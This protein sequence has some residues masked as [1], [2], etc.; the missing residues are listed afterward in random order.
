MGRTWMPLAWL[1]AAASSSQTCRSA[2]RASGGWFHTDI[3]TAG[4]AVERQIS[5]RSSRAKVIG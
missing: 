4:A 3:S 2:G 5:D 1:N